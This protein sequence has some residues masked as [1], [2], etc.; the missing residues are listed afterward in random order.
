MRKISPTELVTLHIARDFEELSQE[1]AI[2]VKNIL[3][4]DQK[5]N[6]IIV[7]GGS[8][9]KRFLQ[10]LGDEVNSWEGIEV[11][12]SDER[13]V[14]KTNEHSNFGMIE[15]EF[16]NK[17][18]GSQPKL[19]NFFQENSNAAE[20]QRLADKKL[21]QLSELDKLISVLGFG[22]DGH[23]AS[24]F[25]G[26]EENMDFNKSS[27]L[28]QK[29]GDNFHRFSLGCKV[30]LSSSRMIFLLKGRDKANPLYDAIMGPYVPE[31]YPSQLLLRNYGKPI[32]IFCDEAA[33][34]KF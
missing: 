12:L 16:L 19:M 30:L 27:L 5:Y 24:L 26:N 15:R 3:D 14:P 2:F 22:T 7:P 33:V 18:K 34:I 6:K 11:I 13:L 17:I 31:K 8:T 23:T 28:F 10:N 25:P 4:N 9:P 32:D 29:Q 1:S 21:D 20:M